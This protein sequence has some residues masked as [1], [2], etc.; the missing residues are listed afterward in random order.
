[1]HS[2]LKTKRNENA[3][4]NPRVT[5][6]SLPPRR[7]KQILELSFPRGVS[8]TREEEG[9]GGDVASQNKGNVL[10]DLH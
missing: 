8:W 6:R 5:W 4:P 7:A 1:M 3:A 9:G 10:L 2:A